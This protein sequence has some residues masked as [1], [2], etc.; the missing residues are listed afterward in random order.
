MLR[1]GRRSLVG[2]VALVE[3]GRIADGGVAWVTTR[4]L[5]TGVAP[6]AYPAAE[7]SSSNGLRI[8]AKW[9]DATCV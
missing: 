3:L 8:L 9:A 4:G 2:C 7:S 1:L 5:P 6:G